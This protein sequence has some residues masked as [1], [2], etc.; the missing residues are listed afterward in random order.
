MDA[1]GVRVSFHILGDATDDAAPTAMFQMPP[2]LELPRHGHP[3]QRL[4]V[5]I[6]G[7][8]HVGDRVHG[9]GPYWR[10]TTRRLKD[11]TTQVRMGASRWNSS[12]LALERTR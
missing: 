9:P 1:Q 2:G 8:L 11:R 4:E 3:C 7:T 10:R 6:E 12:Q 5:V